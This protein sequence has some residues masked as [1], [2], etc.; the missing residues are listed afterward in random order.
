MN[1][2]KSNVLVWNT[3]LEDIKRPSQSHLYEYCYNN[4]HIALDILSNF[5]PDFVPNFWIGPGWISTVFDLHQ[6]LVKLDPNYI[7][8]QIKEKFGA[9]RFY[10]EPVDSI[11]AES[12]NLLIADAE[13]K[14]MI[15]C[16]L[17]S[18][19]AKVIKDKYLF[20]TLCNDCP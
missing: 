16:E 6:E 14:S 1:D 5:H 19:P 13:T 17:C 15:T 8:Y 4:T 7:I 10:A 11:N 2:S 20:R 18:L 3:Y 9:L 12:F